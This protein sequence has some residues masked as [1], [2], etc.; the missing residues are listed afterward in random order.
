[1]ESSIP[2][3]HELSGHRVRFG[4]H[5]LRIRLEVAEDALGPIQRDLEERDGL[6]DPLIGLG[7]TEAEEAAAGVAEALAAEAGDAEVL[8]GA[9][10]QIEGQTVRG[11]PQ[12]IT[13]DADIR[14]HVERPG[15]SGHAEALNALQGVAE[16]DDLA[17]EA[18]HVL[19]AGLGVPF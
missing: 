14:E 2:L 8:V 19:V 3:L 17:P 9:L 15:R 5:E 1:M 16:S 11:D 12:A 13:E 7:A 6:V 18:L 10:E 4:E